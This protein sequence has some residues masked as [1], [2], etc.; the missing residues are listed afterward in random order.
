MN[1]QMLAIIGAGLLLL[2]ISRRV[3]AKSLIMGFEGLSLDRYT[4]PSGFDHIGFG[5]K[6]LPGE[7]WETIDL[8]F[9]QRLLE[10]DMLW[11]SECVRD[12][13]SVPLSGNQRAALVSFVY[14]VGCD[15]FR[16]STLLKFLEVGNVESA[17]NEFLVW[18]KSA[19]VELTA[20]VK[21]REK[22]REVFLG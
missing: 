21:R 3:S 14:N 20:L 9:A 5:H 7:D 2:T 8:P 19:G 18:N 16:R 17:G 15:A 4:D 12:N 6:L 13:V 11:A 1:N 22:E 10:K